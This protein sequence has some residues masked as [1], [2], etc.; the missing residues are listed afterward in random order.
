[1]LRSVVLISGDGNHKTTLRGSVDVS[2]LEGRNARMME[3]ARLLLQRSPVRKTN[4]SMHSHGCKWSGDFRFTNIIIAVLVEISTLEPRAQNSWFNLSTLHNH[5]RRRQLVRRWWRSSLVWIKGVI[6]PVADGKRRIRGL[7][8]L[9]R[10]FFEC[11]THHT[12]GA[13]EYFPVEE[14]LSLLWSSNKYPTNRTSE[15]ILS[16]VTH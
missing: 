16:K 14:I 4:S 6:H 8:G 1:M 15:E 11:N 13:A 12:P 5:M 3:L 10:M 9:K 7:K 2:I